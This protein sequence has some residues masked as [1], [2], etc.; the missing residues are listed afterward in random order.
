MRLRSYGDVLGKFDVICIIVIN[1]SI[2]P[3][4]IETFTFILEVF[5]AVT[6]YPYYNMCAIFICLAVS[7][8][9][10]V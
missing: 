3:H 10:L 2:L 5:S 6:S 1:S 4:S 8:Y 7:Q 9:L